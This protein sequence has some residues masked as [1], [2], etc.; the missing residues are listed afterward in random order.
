MMGTNDD[1][2]PVS[3]GW[4]GDC[5]TMFDPQIADC[6]GTI[7]TTFTHTPATGM[8]DTTDPPPASVIVAE[9]ASAEADAY[10]TP[11]GD[12][13]AS[14][15]D[16]IGQTGTLDEWQDIEGG[17]DVGTNGEA[18]CSGTRYR[19]V[20][21]ATPLVLTCSPDAS[22]SSSDGYPAHTNVFY[23][24][25]VY[26][27]TI[28]LGGTTLDSNGVDNILIG[29]LCSA[30]LSGIPSGCTVTYDWSVTGPIFQSWTVSSD[31]S[32]TTEVDG[33][34]DATRA[35]PSWYWHETGQ[36]TSFDETVSCTAT[37]T[38]PTGKG[39][40]FTVSA[41][42]PVVVWVPDWAATGVGGYMQVNKSAPGDS[43]YELWAGPTQ[44]EIN[45]GEAHGMNWS[46][47]VATPTSPAFGTG[48]L[49]LVQILTPNDQYDT[50]TN[51]KVTKYDPLNNLL[52][53]D[54][55]YPY[56]SGYET[57]PPVQA[58]DSP[59]LALIGSTYQAFSADIDDSFADYLMYEPPGSG[60]Y[61]PLA[62]FGWYTQGSATIPLTDSW[63]DY[64]NVNGSDAAGT[65]T[66]STSTNY[67]QTNAFPSWTR[68]DAIGG[69]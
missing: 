21:G 19:V 53:L 8:S 18:S 12:V 22:A 16:G 41:A 27:V 3:G 57:D 69:Y 10:T 50:D 58:G 24:A 43:N 45:S 62:T 32:Y 7:T 5:L 55:V 4:G 35:N 66:P 13:S 47:S 46:L 64:A 52:G 20:T 67:A 39:S 15:D 42:K 28:Q 34:G 56:A 37:V 17:Q 54:G 31:Q 30:T 25:G 59:G 44:A 26:P 51:P 1:D 61:V 48:S 49:E 2:G 33:I 40:P 68:I 11:A 14:C 29:Q 60:Q 6:E 9:T 63:S 36:N 23:V 65:V 38:P